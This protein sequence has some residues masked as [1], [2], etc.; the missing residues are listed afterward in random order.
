MELPDDLFD[1][2]GSAPL[3]TRKPS[4]RERDYLSTA[5]YE[6]KYKEKT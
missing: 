2:V 1:Y 6:L 3:Y 5:A 4:S